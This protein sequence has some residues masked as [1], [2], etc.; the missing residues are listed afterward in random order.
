LTTGSDNLNGPGLV[1]H[2]RHDDHAWDDTPGPAPLR[3]LAQPDSDS[4]SEPY[5]DRASLTTVTA[6]D[7]IILL[8]RVVQHHA[9]G[10]NSNT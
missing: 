9:S 4:Y 1:D 7:R 10:H 3:S 5:R 6:R 2:H 8:Y